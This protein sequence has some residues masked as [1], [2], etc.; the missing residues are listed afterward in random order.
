MCSGQDLE[1]LL[2]NRDRLLLVTDLLL[3]LRHISDGCRTRGTTHVGYGGI[4]GKK[5][6]HLLH[7]ETAAVNLTGSS[8]V[9][10]GLTETV[11]T[12]HW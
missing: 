7:P 10:L 1:E 6:E 3:P 4:V 5:N 12:R 2:S 9:M 8:M 11:L